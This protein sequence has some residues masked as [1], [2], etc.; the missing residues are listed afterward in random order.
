MVLSANSAAVTGLSW[1]L[2]KRAVLMS[3]AGT[4]TASADTADFL[5]PVPFNMTATLLKVTYKTNPTTDATIQ[6]RTSTDETMWSDLGAGTS[7]VF[8][9]AGNRTQEFNITDTEMTEGHT[10]N[11]SVT[12][13]ADGVNIVVMVV[14]FQT[15]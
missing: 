3:M 8:A 15:A 7:G 12:G 4:V 9:T 11:F 10:L 1:V 2:S 14:G 13:G 6:L 5:I